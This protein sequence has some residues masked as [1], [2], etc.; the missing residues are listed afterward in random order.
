MTD[1]EVDTASEKTQCPTLITKSLLQQNI[2]IIRG[3]EIPPKS[4]GA[5]R[6]Y[7]KGD[8]GK[9]KGKLTYQRKISII[10]GYPMLSGL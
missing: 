4:G 9:K 3:K 2:L 6:R 8:E 1:P 5:I 7:G 10:K